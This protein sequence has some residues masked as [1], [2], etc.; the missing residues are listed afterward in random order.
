MFII[1]MERLHVSMEVACALHCFQGLSI[2]NNGFYIS[3]LIYV[4][5]VTFVG[6][7]LELNFF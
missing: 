5:D 1:A 2:G 3:L 6:E 4:N 7:W